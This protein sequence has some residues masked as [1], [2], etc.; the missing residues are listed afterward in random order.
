MTKYQEL[1]A[2]AKYGMVLPEEVNESAKKL[3]TWMKYYVH[4]LESEIID[5]KYD[6]A[7]D[8]PQ[9]PCTVMDFC[10]CF[11]SHINGH[12]EDEDGWSEEFCPFCDFTKEMPQRTA[13]EYKTE[14]QRW[15]HT[16]K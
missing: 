14:I 6:G 9:F 5:Q 11:E 7:S 3:V 12:P 16:F 1:S 15:C 2:K 13:D 8:A 4:L 10:G